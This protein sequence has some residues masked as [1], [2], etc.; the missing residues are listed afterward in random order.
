[1]RRTPGFR[2]AQP[3]LPFISIR[4]DG[5]RAND[6]SPFRQ[7]ALDQSRDLARSCRERLKAKRNQPLIEDRL[8]VRVVEHEGSLEVSAVDGLDATLDVAA[9]D[10]LSQPRARWQQ[11]VEPP[12]RSSQ[13]RES[14]WEAQGEAL[15]QTT[16]RAVSTAIGWRTI[17][18]FSR[19]MTRPVSR[20][21]R[22]VVLFARAPVCG[23][24]VQPHRC[25]TLAM[26]TFR[27][28]RPESCLPVRVADTI[29]SWPLQ[30]HP[31]MFRTRS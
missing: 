16:A 29:A 28:P 27:R 10:R 30:P 4:L 15:I 31:P 6:A 5:R 3:G 1:M 19:G 23:S 8:D 14:A 18:T 17:S 11:Q 20:C 13:Q 22:S 9:D 21:R 26:C 25:I 24:M 12:S 7:L 2:S